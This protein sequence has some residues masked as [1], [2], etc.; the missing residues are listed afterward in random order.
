MLAKRQGLL[1]NA[2]VLNTDYLPTFTDL[3]GAQ[4]PGYTDGRSLRPLL[5]GNA[6]AW[7]GA[8]LLEG[9]CTP[10]GGPTPAFSGIRTSG[11]TKYVEYAGGER[12]L[13]ALGRDPYERYNR[14]PAARPPQVWSR[15]CTR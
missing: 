2:L 1:A 12:E 4:T 6:T 8:V 9:H 15:A 13:Y 3:A 10:E 5:K 7:R 14:Y 11:G